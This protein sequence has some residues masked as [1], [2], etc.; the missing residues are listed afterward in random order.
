MIRTRPG[1]E[2][3]LAKNEQPEQKQP[4]A[5]TLGPGRGRG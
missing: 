4:Q 5:I 1:R 2:E 3:V